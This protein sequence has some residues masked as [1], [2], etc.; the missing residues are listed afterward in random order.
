MNN[1]RS[2]SRYYPKVAR[3]ADRR[4]RPRLPDREILDAILCA[5]R[6]GAAW[7][8][9]PDRSPSHQT[10]HRRLQ[11]WRKPG[12]FETV[13]RALA[14][15]LRQRAG[16][17]LDEC[18]IDGTFVMVKSGAPRWEKPSGTEVTLVQKTLGALFVDERPT[19]LIGDKAYDSDPLDQQLAGR[20]IDMIAPHRHNRR[21]PR[22]QDGRKLR[23]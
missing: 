23:R 2:L 18:F 9:L 13:L 17:D 6:T 10:C 7:H 20:G 21:R 12:V 1:G 19:R 3:R 16:L 15:D 8:D 5:L 14:E 4:G 22:S 11:E